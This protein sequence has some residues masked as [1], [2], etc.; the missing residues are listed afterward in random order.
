M[1][2]LLFLLIISI[3]TS[4]AYGCNSAK[5]MPFSATENLKEESIG[6]K[7]DKIILSKG[8]Q[9]IEPS[10][11]V[12]KKDNSL[13]LLASLGLIESSGVTIDK[14][15]KSGQEIN[16]YIDRL[17][18]KDEVQLSVPQILLEID[19]P[20][21]EKLEELNF[22]IISQNYKPIVLKFSK[23]QILNKIYSQF[24]IS[25]T[26]I[27]AVELSKLGD[28]IFWNISF[29]SI[30]D[31]KN[32]QSPLVNLDVKIDANTG[33]ILESK[34][35]TISTYIDDGYLLDYIPNNSLLYKRQHIKNDNKYE[36]LWIYN[37][38]TGKRSKLYTSK[39]KIDS[40]LFSP[41]GK[42]IS[43]IEVNESQA[44]LYIIPMSDKMTYKITPAEHLQPRL[45]KWKNDN[46]I[47]FVNIDNEKCTLLSYDVNKNKTKVEFNLDKTIED[48]D[49]LN[50]KFLFIESDK[51]SL[52]KNIYITEDGLTLEKIDIGFK[53]RFFDDNNII[54]LKNMEKDDKNILH[55]YNLENKDEQKNLN[56]NITN[57]F[58][59][60][61]ENIA[62][63]EKNTCNNN[64][65]LTKYNV[66]E[67][68]IEP[69]A[70]IT[71]DKIFYDSDKEKGYMSLSPPYDDNEKNTIYSIDLNSLN[72]N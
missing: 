63:V 56:Y 29:H 16:I 33:E 30:F 35:Y 14:I 3:L 54:Y 48:F 34:K 1:K 15:T 64:Y 20:I 26:T 45:M 62:F 19:D 7:I 70:K 58:K 37:T 41:D 2:K 47:C 69:I 43:L 4:A 18:N 38:E 39:D 21:V 49:I 31:N 61:K 13:K 67:N 25:P 22:N 52:N 51:D 11:E 8:F 32:P 5:E 57:Y 46:I 44:D 42:Y 27:P 23:N 9:T 68:T 40:A 10:V 24:K 66:L 6:Y 17:L 36:S 12:V 59:L 28:G 50:N 60:N 72:K 65:T 53:A 55:S 71:D